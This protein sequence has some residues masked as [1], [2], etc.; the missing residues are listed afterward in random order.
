MR[1][2]KHA[3]ERAKDRFG[4]SE[5]E[6]GKI[7]EKEFHSATFYRD[8]DDQGL[9]YY[10]KDRN[11][12][13]VQ[14]KDRKAIVTVYPMEDNSKLD[15]CDV[16]EYELREFLE[17]RRY[18]FKKDFAAELT[19]V[20]SEMSELSHDL[21]RTMRQL[22]VDDKFYKLESMVDDLKGLFDHKDEVM[23]S[24]NAIERKLKGGK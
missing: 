15:V 10:L 3:Y 20:T 16:V 19:E 11:M 12:V 9:K 17:E 1:I 8:G 6:M 4:I 21:S 13:L 7:V 24:Y 5:S 14:S 2:T 23:E 18:R 22:Y